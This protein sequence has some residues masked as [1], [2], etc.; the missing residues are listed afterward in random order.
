[1]TIPMTTLRRARNG[2][3]LSRKAIPADVREAY[4]AAHGVSQEERFRRDA[5]MPVERAKQEMREWD[6]TISGRI[7]ALRAA[8][9]GE[10]QSLTK[11][12][13]HAL[14]GEWYLWF[15]AQHEDE[16]GTAEHWDLNMGWL[17]GAYLRFGSVNAGRPDADDDWDSPIIRRHVRATV[18]EVAHIPT[19]L[20]EHSR[21]LNPEAYG[22][23]LDTVEAEYVAALALLRRRADGDY[24]KD[25][26]PLRFPEI[27]EQ[28]RNGKVGLSCWGVFEAWVRERK[29]AP[30]TVNRW[31]SVFL[32]LDE[33]FKGRDIASRTT[34]EAINWKGTLV[35]E[36]RSAAVANDIWLRA[37]R[38]VFG[39]ALD[40][41]MIRA[42]PFGGVSIAAAA[43]SV[44]LREREFREEEWRTIL[45]ASFAPPP[46]RM[47]RHNA[48][49][50][51]WVP[52]LCA[53]TGSRPGE[54]TQLRAQDVQSDNGVWVVR[55][56]PEA[57]AVKGRRA[58]VVPLH[59]HL[60]EQGFVKLTQAQGSGPLFYDPSGRRTDAADPL[61]PVRAPWVKAREKLAGWVRLLG[62]ADPNI[63]PNHA[64]RH[65]FKRRARR[66]GIERHIRDAICGHT[67][68]DVADRYEAPTVEDMTAAL[69]KFP[70]Y[71]LTHRERTANQ[72]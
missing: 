62:V 48:L 12:E 17:E 18:A 27:S 8:R 33:R 28:Q 45:N 49:A 32:V 42:N 68:R 58:R 23:F 38:T 69:A 56:T 26:R 66:A 70:R 52:W 60:I 63:S 65:T 25:N 16:P 67:L 57:G 37:A 64:W 53:Y 39:W 4:R 59:E 11:R 40:N 51:R 30:S 10:G 2:G 6:A 50:R 22:L 44:E 29:P 9:R 61:K 47:S 43:K 72:S 7:N 20:A 71:S 46:P 19:F 1:M 21:T 14:A 36:E 54:I 24:S 15:V 41:K 3:W 5:S 13:T 34:D 55:I 31:R 35:T